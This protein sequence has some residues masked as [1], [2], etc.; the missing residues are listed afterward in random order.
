VYG[1]GWYAASDCKPNHINALDGNGL[2]AL[3]AKRT[4]R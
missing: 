2:L 3:I 4:P 1:Q